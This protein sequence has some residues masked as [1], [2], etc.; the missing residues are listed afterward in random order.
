MEKSLAWESESGPAG[1]C[2]SQQPGTSSNLEKES[3]GLCSQP[4][5]LGRRRPR[6]ENTG[7]AY[8]EEERG[9]ASKC[10]PG[11]AKK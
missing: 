2:D 9:G 11:W 7:E 3:P 8:T 1:L 4:A 6:P 10:S 5:K